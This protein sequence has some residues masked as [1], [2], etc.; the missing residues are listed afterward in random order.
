MRSVHQDKAHRFKVKFSPRTPGQSSIDACKDCTLSLLKLIPISE[1][2]S[3]SVSSS[4]QTAEEGASHPE[5]SSQSVPMD[6][7]S[8]PA[9]VASLPTATEAN[10]TARANRAKFPLRRDKEIPV[11]EIA[12]V[13][14]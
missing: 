12:K 14:I 6:C 13:T 5:E 9:E 3:A 4:Q 11:S 10:G 1:L 2:S 8:V 7:S